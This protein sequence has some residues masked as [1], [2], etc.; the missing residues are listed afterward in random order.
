MPAYL[1]PGVYFES[2]DIA[3][4]G[5]PAL[6]TDIAAFIGIAQ[7]GPVSVP[8]PVNSWE[9]F[10][11]VFGTYLPNGY[12][13]Y[14]A[15]AFFENGGQK[16]YGL[17][18]A[19]P[20]ASTTTD[21]AAVQ[22]ADG[23]A[24]I[25]ISVHGFAVGALATI[26]QTALA[27]AVGAQPA[28]RA[29][30]IVDTTGGFPEDSVVAITQTVPVVRRTFAKVLSADPA[31]KRIFWYA[32]L[33]P[34]YVLANPIQFVAMHHADRLVQSLDAASRKIIWSTALGNSF[35]LSQSIQIDTGARP[36]HGALFDAQ[37]V[38][39]LRIE[40]ASPGVWGD[41]LTVHL[42]RSSP[43]A[44]ATTSSAQPATGLASLVG[45]VVGFAKRSL[46]KAFQP[47]VPP[48]YVIVADVG[49]AGN[50][51][52]WNSPLVA[53]LD[54]T[55]TIYFETIEFALTVYEQG[56]PRELFP[57]LSLDK[58]HAR[59]VETAVNQDTSRFIRAL[60]LNSP[61]PYPDRLPDPASPRLDNGVLRLWGGGDGVA[62]LT[63]MDFTGD[64]T[65]QQKWG[66]RTFE[67]IDEI[68]IVSAPDVLI[69]PSP[70][71]LF[72][73]LPPPLPDPCLPGQPPPIVAPGP[74][75]VAVEASPQF[76]LDEVSRVQQ[77]MVSHCEAMQFRFAILDPPDFD[78]PKQHVDLG[79]VQS[80]RS[81]FDSKYA[82]LYYP[83][84][85]VRDPLALANQVVRRI[86]PSGHIAGVYANTDLTIGVHKAPANFELF[87]AQDVTTD[88][89]REMQG[90]LNPVGVNCVRVFP[91][92]GLRVYGARTV[93]SDANW[94]FVN[95]RRLISMI[96]HALEISMQW[97]VFEPNNIYLWQLVRTSISVFL[98]KQWEKGA[99]LGN[100]AEDAFFVHCDQLNN[101][102]ATTSVGQMIAEVGVAPTLPA[103][104]VVFRIGRTEDTLEIT[105]QGQAA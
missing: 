91:G 100:T 94:Q 63:T 29:S 86:P 98:E 54:L 84:I 89:S 42:A 34:G 3:T 2:A 8:T 45:S 73:P 77:A 72:E 56:I 49:P 9:Q 87:W 24:S 85:F 39:T 47:G 17:R 22:P 1:T 93:S 12:L 92:R 69:E 37:G 6:R 79:E 80:W 20:A 13:A 31:A 51:L 101:S 50:V 59:Y 82:A 61:S 26:Q 21:L 70:P 105:E 48:Q 40:A 66:L 33:D 78:F 44:T 15:K 43:A 36:A 30:S 97:A 88:V 41:A 16:L 10:Q 4:P 52:N 95:V 53:P 64:P 75:F 102:L 28:D 19:A 99:L 65:S 7:M 55:K 103:E 83:W 57:G 90:V 18:V 32:P 5:I 11:A 76:S 81:R 74:P 23:S 60:D 68:S 104:F 58:L 14:C 46:V 25:V 62:A 71:R 27:N 35:N 67:D 38:P 96:E